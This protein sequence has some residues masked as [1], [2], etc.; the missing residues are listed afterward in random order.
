MSTLR[1]HA[2]KLASE[3]PTGNPTRRKLLAALKEAWRPRR[4]PDEEYERWKDMRHEREEEERLEAEARNARA[5]HVAK[6]KADLVKALKRAFPKMKRDGGDYRIP[7]GDVDDATKVILRAG[8][9][10]T[11]SRYREQANFKKDYY[12]MVIYVE[13]REHDDLIVFFG[14]DDIW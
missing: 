9:K 7:Y 12:G 5:R 11:G 14:D 1:S 3:L 13:P 10:Q 4:D 2:L 8:W 6:I